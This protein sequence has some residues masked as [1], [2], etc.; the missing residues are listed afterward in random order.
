MAR[1]KTAQQVKFAKAAK[2]CKG[3][4]IRAFRACVRQKLKKGR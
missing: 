2:A 1:R 4:K 3:K